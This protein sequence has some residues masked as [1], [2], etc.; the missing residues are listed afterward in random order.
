MTT[1]SLGLAEG[2]VDRALAGKMASDGYHHGMSRAFTKERDDLPQ[3]EPVSV[4]ARSPLVTPAGLERWRE[5]LARTNDPQERERL[6]RRI[7]EAVV[8]D[9]P[10]DR[11]HVAFGAT[12]VVRGAAEDRPTTFTI[13]GEDEADVKTGKISPGSPLAQALLGAAVKEQVV[14]HRPAGDRTLTVE[15]ISY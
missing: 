15:K 8:V 6:A 10:E 3:P 9:P 2:A 13:V 12:V 14:W 7:E 11:D 1:G 4:R 5:E